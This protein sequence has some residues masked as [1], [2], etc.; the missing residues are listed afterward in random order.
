MCDSVDWQ[1]LGKIAQI[2]FPDIA[3]WYNRCSLGTKRENERLRDMEIV[4]LRSCPKSGLFY[5]GRAGQ[6]E[7]IL[8]DGVPWIAK[9][10]R[11][12]RDLRGRNLPSY[13]SSPVS[14][15]LGARIYASLGILAHETMLGYRNGKIV[16][17]CKD[18]T[19]PD[20]RLFE[21]KDIKNALSDDDLGFDSA[22]SDGESIYLGDVL[23]TIE[24]SEVLKATPGVPARFWD[25]FVV[26][27]FIKNPDRSNGNWGLLLNPNR[28]YELAPVYDLGSSLFSKRSP[29][30]AEQR[31]AHEPDI[32]QD[33]FGTNVSC[34]RLLRDDGSSEAIHPFEYMARSVNPDL[35]AA[36]ERFVERVDLGAIERI[37]DD[38]PYEAYGRVIMSEKVKDSHKVLLKRRLEEG[39]LPIYG[40]LR[41]AG[42]LPKQ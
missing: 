38:V 33:A 30:V 2:P 31:L 29:Q 36:I 14:E 22:P 16:C 5:G 24:T 18:F 25:M 10:P 35:A 8:I 1:R 11:T 7:G 27:A 12:T 21:F 4:D 32:E 15:F 34:Y 42:L 20:K 41:N 3:P 28:S 26:D 13:T 6:K 9:Y 39:F 23:A 17:A 37:I 19:H 40:R